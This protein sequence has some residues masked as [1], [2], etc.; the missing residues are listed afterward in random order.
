MNF[1]K[2]TKKNGFS[3]IEALFGLVIFSVFL[4]IFLETQSHT[5]KFL[6][7]GL[8]S[9]DMQFELN[10]IN[11]IMLA[12]PEWE[13]VSENNLK[14]NITIKQYALYREVIIC[15]KSKKM[16]CL[17]QVVPNQKTDFHL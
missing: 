3:L 9:S 12:Y 16:D 17:S 7:E 11:E 8:K 6:Y 14:N 4:Q 10:R 13:E 15:G 5:F 1:F 2:L